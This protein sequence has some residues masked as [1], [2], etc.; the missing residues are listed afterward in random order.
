MHVRSKQETRQSWTIRRQCWKYKIPV[1]TK[2]DI[3]SL[4][5]P[6]VKFQEAKSDYLEQ[7]NVNPEI[8]AKQIKAT[9][10]NKSPGVGGIPS[11]GNILNGKKQSS[12]IPLFKKV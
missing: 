10:D 2:E 12:Y 1:F 11:N 3:S 4:P 6:D 8:V 5:V 7:L 9:K